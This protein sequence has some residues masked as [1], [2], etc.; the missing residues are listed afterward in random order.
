MVLGKKTLLTLLVIIVG[1]SVSIVE[2]YFWVEAGKSKDSKTYEYEF[3][4][5]Y[6]NGEVHEKFNALRENGVVPRLTMFEGERVVNASFFRDIHEYHYLIKELMRPLEFSTMVSINLLNDIVKLQ[7]KGLAHVPDYKALGDAL[8]ELSLLIQGFKKREDRLNSYLPE[9]ISAFE[10]D[11]DMKD[12]E[13]IELT[14]KQVKLLH[15]LY[16]NE[17]LFLKRDLDPFKIVRELGENSYKMLNN[18]EQILSGYNK[19][20]SQEDTYKKVLLL[21]LT[22]TSVY[23]SALIVLIPEHHIKNK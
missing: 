11:T 17:A 2:A 21:I 18:Y 15:E 13:K 10:Y 12:S 9:L 5:N 4:L 14:V 6:W 16:S 22:L 3:Q 19:Q 20:V 7:E 8:E 1:L 23:L